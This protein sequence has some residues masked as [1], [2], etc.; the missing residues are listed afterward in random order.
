[1]TASALCSNKELNLKVNLAPN[2]YLL[3]KSMFEF[4]NEFNNAFEVTEDFI[5]KYEE[6]YLKQNKS[7]LTKDLKLSSEIKPNQMQIEA[8]NRPKNLRANGKN[9]AL[10]ISATGTGKTFLSAFDVKA[11]NAKKVLFVVH[12]ENIAR[13]ALAAYKSIFEDSYTYGFYTGGLKDVDADFIFSTIQTISKPDN[14]KKFDINHFDYIV[15]D[16][17]HRAGAKSYHEV[18]NYFKPKFLLGM[19]ATPERTDGEDIFTLYDHNIA[20]EIRLH[21]ALEEK[22]LAPFHYF[23][24]TDITVN[25]KEV[26]SFSDFKSLV[27]KERVDRIIE[28]A[29]LYG[30]DSGVI[31]GLVFCSRNE[32]SKELCEIFN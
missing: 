20:Y 23:G 21:A 19:T 5:E 28:N 17:S 8:L 4:S 25:G 12:R 16:E 30:C 27:A 6:I 26:D 32:E 24:V 29:R 3:E 1:M 14:I 9:K 7:N 15:I 31:R 11:I 13:A 18:L 2:S 22:I 10:L